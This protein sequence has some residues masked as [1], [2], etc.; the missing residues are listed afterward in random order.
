MSFEE[1][2]A[3]LSLLLSQLDNQPDDEHEIMMRLKQMLDTMRSEGLPIPG[4]LAKL[5]ADLD[6]LFSGKS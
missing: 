6:E 4:D 1:Y 5:E 3:E 2:Q